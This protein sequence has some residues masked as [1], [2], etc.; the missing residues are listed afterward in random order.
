MPAL[1]RVGNVEE[2]GEDGDLNEL[3]WRGTRNMSVLGPKMAEWLFTGLLLSHRRS[4]S[5]NMWPFVLMCKWCSEQSVYH[6]VRNLRLS[7]SVLCL[8]Q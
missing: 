8:L 7:C 4:T 5:E 2:A 6:V 3:D 1:E